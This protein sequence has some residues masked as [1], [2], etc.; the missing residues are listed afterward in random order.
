MNVKYMIKLLEKCSADARECYPND[1]ELRSLY[2]ARALGTELAVLG[3]PCGPVIA[4]LMSARSNANYMADREL[5][6]ATAI[7]AAAA[8]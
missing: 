1:A 4:N 8:R 6:A 2:F 3:E 5:D 7:Q